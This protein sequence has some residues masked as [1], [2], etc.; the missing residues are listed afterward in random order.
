MND[1]YDVNNKIYELDFQNLNQAKNKIV[2][3]INGWK[4]KIEKIE[5]KSEFDNA[6]KVICKDKEPKKY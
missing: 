5:I 6:I 2:K 3:D 4:A 1:F